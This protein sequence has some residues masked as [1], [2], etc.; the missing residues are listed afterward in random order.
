VKG[1][2]EESSSVRGADLERRV[3]NI[4]GHGSPFADSH[5]VGRSQ[6]EL[7]RGGGEQIDK[8]LLSVM[9]RD[10]QGR[11]RSPVFLSRDLILDFKCSDGLI[12]RGWSL[13]RDHH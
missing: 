10:T 8:S 5:S 12:E 9:R 3:T 6:S 11:I 13:P 1:E 7:V 4:F 2:R